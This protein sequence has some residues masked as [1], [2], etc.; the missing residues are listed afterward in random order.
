MVRLR[1]T[2]LVMLLLCLTSGCSGPQIGEPAARAALDASAEALGGWDALRAVRS[3]RI[4]TEGSNWEP[5]QAMAPG[6]ELRIT[7]FSSILHVE[8]DQPSAR[9]EFQADILYP[10]EYSSEF[11]EVIQGDLG[12]LEQ[13]GAD[14]VVQRSRLHPARYAARIRDLKRMPVR[15]L[16]TASEAPGLTRL[17]DET[18]NGSALQVL[19]F[20]DSG[21]T[22]RLRLDPETHLPD[23][24]AYF[25][26]EPILG[27]TWN[28]VIWRDWRDVDG[29]MLPYSQDGWL[30]DLLFHEETIQEIENNPSLPATAFAIPDEIRQTPQ[31]GDR[32]VSSWVPRR[33]VSNVSYL[34]F[35]RPPRVEFEELAPGVWLVGGANHQTYVIEMSDHLMTV[36]AP[37]YEERSQPVIQAVQ[38][39]FPDK[40]IRYTVVTHWHLDH[41]GGLRAYAAEGATIVAPASILPFLRTMFTAPKM[42]RPDALARRAAAEGA[43]PEIPME[44][45]DAMKEYTDGTRV[46]HVLPVPTSHVQ[47]MLGVHLPRERIIIEADLVSNTMY[48][49][50]PIVEPRAREYYEWLRQ[51]DLAVDRIARVHGSVVPFREFA[52]IVERAR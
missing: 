13:T 1:L 38:E 41:S 31:E 17:P 34:D 44:G 28:K 9:I 27:D 20:Q 4:V 7:N 46:V 48:R 30:N 21:M 43:P 15:V 35:G 39:K 25:E 37:L 40:P 14:G 26:D 12:M 45:I 8:F 5:L 18:S 32:I 33:V 49:D 6:E 11:T 10:R 29:V 16:L 24:V 47:A 42:I 51:S 22:V 50:P 52:S 36:E 3:Q 23:S 2:A 19:E